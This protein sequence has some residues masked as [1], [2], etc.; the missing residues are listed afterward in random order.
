MGG[1][2][3]WGVEGAA[4]LG[5]AAAPE[6]AQ[7]HKRRRSYSKNGSFRRRVRQNDD[8]CHN[9]REIVRPACSIQRRIC[10]KVRPARPL[11]RCFRKKVR[12]A[13][14]KPPILGHISCAG[15]IFS[16]SRPPSDRAGRTFSRTGSCDVATLK[17]MTP[18]QPLMQTN[19]KPPSPLQPLMQ[20][21]M[22][23]P[24]PMLA[25][26]QR[27]L[28]P[29]SPLQP[30][31]APKTPISRPQRRWRFQLGLSL[32]EQR[33]CRFHPRL[34][35]REQRRRRFQLPPSPARK[36]DG[37]FNPTRARASK[38][39]DGFTREIS[40]ARGR[41]R[42]LARQ[43]ANARATHQR[44]GAA[45]VEGAGGICCGAGGRWRGLAGL[46]DDAPSRRLA[47]RTASGR[48][49][50]HGHT[51]QPG[52]TAGSDG[53]R[54]TSGATSN[55]TRRGRLAG[56]RARRRPEHQRRHKHHRTEKP[57]NSS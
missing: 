16:R 18:L 38:G 7:R 46:R 32:R 50:A 47:A 54:N 8:L 40:D 55:N 14:H 5:R 31:N 57:Q 12:P 27:P 30:K 48:A 22:K 6:S 41:W 28:K 11:Q 45:G 36:G 33:R 10:E 51:E 52:P 44:P 20:A 42:G 17:P 24:A 19:V 3:V 4:G 39:D 23:P 35:L 49:A 26:E 56:G 29:P 25:P 15:R 13:R 43:R 9:R 1:R 53:A 34:A 37:G 2:F 21:N